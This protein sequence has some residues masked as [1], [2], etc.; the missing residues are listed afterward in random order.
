MGWWDSIKNWVSGA[1]NSVKNVASN[2]FNKIKPFISAIP[3]IGDK[4]VTGIET[5]GSAIDSGAKGVGN[6]VSGN[7]G[8]AVGN[9]RDAFNTGKDAIGK[10]T[11]LKKGGMVQPMQY[12]G[13]PMNPEM[14][15][16]YRVPQKY[17]NMFQK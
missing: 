12:G 16:P 14:A 7:I 4:I 11:N 6:L 8:G 9:I 3:L 2:V 17:N 5:L 10:L 13:V 1:Y 15:G